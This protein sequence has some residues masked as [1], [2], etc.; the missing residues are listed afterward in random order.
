MG[1]LFADN[2]PAD[3]E[4]AIEQ[5]PILDLGPYFAGREGALVKLGAEM[6]A[7]SE[8]VGF[9]YV[10]GHGVDDA[11]IEAAFA[12]SKRFHA[13]PIEEK[14]RL[15]IDMNNIGYMAM[16]ASMQRHS[17]VHRNSRPNQNAS[18][19]VSYDRDPEDPDVVA[20][21]PLRGANHWPDLPGFRETV[22]AYFW[23]MHGLGQRLGAV[24]AV[25]LDLPEDYFSPLFGDEPFANLRLLHYPPTQDVAD[26]A[27]GAAPHTDNGFMTLLARE[28][29]VPGLAVRFPDGSWVSPP[30]IPGTFLVNLGNTL[31]RWTNDRFVATPHG[32]VNDA[33]ADRYTLAYFHSVNPGTMI[34]CL[35]TCQDD[36]NKAKYD[37]AQYRDLILEFYNANYFHRK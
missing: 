24:F 10:T 7:A 23:A 22:M 5:I 20:G 4:R 9:F 18:L 25:A 2:P 16:N 19:F 17:T 37:P 34:E 33:E 3:L 8:G 26:N 15:A 11:L 30:V 36:A 1:A 31:R 12:E 14:S 29:G 32:V 13:L 28:P 27:F 35:P 21:T 6:R